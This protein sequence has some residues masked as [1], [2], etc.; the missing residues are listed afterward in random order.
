MVSADMQKVDTNKKKG[1]THKP[2]PSNYDVYGPIDFQVYYTMSLS[3]SV[4]DTFRKKEVI[5]IVLIV[6]TS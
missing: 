1:K 2:S 4:L 6:I 3:T 5:F